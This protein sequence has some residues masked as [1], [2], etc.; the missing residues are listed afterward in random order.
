MVER[1]KEAK[2]EYK[3]KVK[4]LK[5]KQKREVRNKNLSLRKIELRDLK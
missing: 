2:D 5:K 3:I 1:I 4:N